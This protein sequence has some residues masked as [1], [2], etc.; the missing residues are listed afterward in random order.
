MERAQEVTKAKQVVRSLITRFS[1]PGHRIHGDAA[2]DNANRLRAL[3]GICGQCSNL[4]LRFGRKDGKSIV[5]L[6]C[7][8]GHRPSAV[9]ERTPLGEKA[10]C[11]DYS[12][13]K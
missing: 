2:M 10:I 7:S 4:G 12:K 6:G 8:A 13:A 1:K 11:K 9:Y 3:E 5:T